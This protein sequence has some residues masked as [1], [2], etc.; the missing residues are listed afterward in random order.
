MCNEPSILGVLLNG[1]L[2]AGFNLPKF[3]IASAI[4]GR[5]RK[6]RFAIET[7]RNCRETEL[8]VYLSGESFGFENPTTGVS[9]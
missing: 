8:M 7:E 2:L 6:E 9:H 3:K 5:D 4:C 1:D